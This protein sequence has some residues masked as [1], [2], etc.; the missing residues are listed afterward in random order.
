MSVSSRVVVGLTLQFKGKLSTADW[1]KI[2]A[3]EEKYPELDEYSYNYN[4]RAGKLLLISDGMNGEFCRLIKVDKYVDGKSLGE[5]N[6]F[7]ELNMPE[8][9]LNQELISRMSELYKEFTG[10][11]PKN[12][13]FKYTMWSQWY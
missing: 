9:V 3:M 6:E 5:A 13:D 11:Y 8:G 4:D 2:H 10:E 1:R 12:T 7:V